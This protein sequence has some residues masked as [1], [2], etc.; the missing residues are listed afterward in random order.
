MQSD[1][2]QFGLATSQKIYHRI[3][4]GTSQVNEKTKALMNDKKL[5]LV[6]DLDNTLM[7]SRDYRMRPEMAKHKLYSKA[8]GSKLI[9]ADMSIYHIWAPRTFSFYVKLRPFCAEFL[10]EAMQNYEVH[11]NTAAVRTYGIL[12][13][14]ILKFEVNMRKTRM[15]KESG[16]EKDEAFRKQVDMTYDKN[17]LITRDDKARFAEGGGSKDAL[18]Q[19]QI[20]AIR[21][22]EKNILNRGVT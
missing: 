13:L 10:I 5:V 2:R 14:G 22:A 12:I 19:G 3:D 16:T 8:C 6:L 9:D 21:Q 18:Q 20:E 11:F 4:F 1:Y 7:H 15:E 17:R